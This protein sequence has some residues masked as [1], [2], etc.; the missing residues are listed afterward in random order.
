MIKIVKDIRWLASGPR[1]APAELKPHSKRT[2]KL[3][4]PGRVNPTQCESMV[5]A[6]IQTLGDDTATGITGS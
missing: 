3:D 5:M 2:R 1:A 6:C 4:L